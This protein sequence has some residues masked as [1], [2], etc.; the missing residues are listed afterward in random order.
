MAK[1]NNKKTS[2][3]G[4]I[5]DSQVNWFKAQAVP[6]DNDSWIYV[7]ARDGELRIYRTTKPY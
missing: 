7:T 2:I 5:V 6:Y 1:N 3:S 4:S